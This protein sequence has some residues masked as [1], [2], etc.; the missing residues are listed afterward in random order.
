MSIVVGVAA[1]LGGGGP[2]TRRWIVWSD[3]IDSHGLAEVAVRLPAGELEEL[4]AVGGHVERNPVD[5]REHRLD[6]RQI[7]RGR[8]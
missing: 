3:G 6:R 2:Q 5:R 1:R 4:A 8:S 7:L